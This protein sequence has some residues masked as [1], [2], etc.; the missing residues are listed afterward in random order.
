MNIPAPALW[1]GLGGLIPFAVATT[2][3]WLQP[4]PVVKQLAWQGL[5]HYGAVILSFVGAVHWG[6]GLGH[7]DA[8]QQWRVLILSVIPALLAWIALSLPPTWGVGLLLLGFS[9]Q[10]GAEQGGIF[11]GIPPWYLLLRLYLTVGVGSCLALALVT[12]L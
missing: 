6:V 1:L 2:V 9:T 12:L 3:L 7:S 4:T 5:H 8:T 10:Y 11:H